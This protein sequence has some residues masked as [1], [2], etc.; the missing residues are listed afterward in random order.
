MNPT[1]HIVVDPLCGWCYGAKP[2][3]EAAL[4]LEGLDIAVHG[5]GMI[6]DENRKHIT[7]EWKAFVTPH[8]QRIEAI[9]QQPFGDAYKNGLLNDSSV[10]LDSEPPIKAIM[11]AEEMGFSTLKILTALQ[12][13]M[14]FDGRNICIPETIYDI[15]AELGLSKDD[16]KARFDGFEDRE[17]DAHIFHARRMLHT[18]EG[19]G[20]PSAGLINRG[21][22]ATPVNIAAYYGNPEGW[23][24]QLEGLMAGG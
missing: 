3:F 22:E 19:N 13:A 14:Y 15:V 12:T 4:T 5:G 23:L 24:A 1:L 11:A 17:F 9:T 2:L 10:L 18:V 6:T 20:F 7:P 21:T 16:F 8:D